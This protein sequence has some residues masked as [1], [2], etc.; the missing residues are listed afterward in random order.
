M[1]SSYEGGEPT[2]TSDAGQGFTYNQDV[3]Q[4]QAA[5]SNQQWQGQQYVTEQNQ[6]YQGDVN[7]AASANS[8]FSEYSTTTGTETC[9]DTTDYGESMTSQAGFDYYRQST[10]RSR[11]DTA[12]TITGPTHRQRT[13]SG[14]THQ[15]RSRTAPG[16]GGAGG[17]WFSGLFNKL[18]SKNGKEIHLPDDNSQSIVWD[19][20]KKKWVNTLGGDDDDSVPQGP[21]PSDMELIKQQAGPSAGPG[22]LAPPVGVNKFSRKTNAARYVDVLNNDS[23]APSVPTPSSLLPPIQSATTAPVNF[24]IPEAAPDTNEANTQQQQPQQQQQNNSK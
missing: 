21:P 17:G 14:S 3:S 16:T 12:D 4:Q 24:Y 7:L 10:Q 13:Q 23:S 9:G 19:S 1:K 15:S 22:G 6:Q 11:A 8:N 2:P 20:E 18:R 5:Y